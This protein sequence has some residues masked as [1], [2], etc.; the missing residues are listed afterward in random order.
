MDNIKNTTYEQTKQMTFNL[1]SVSSYFLNANIPKLTEYKFLNVTKNKNITIVSFNNKKHFNS[2]NLDLSI[3]LTD[4]NSDIRKGQFYIFKGDETNTFFCTGGDLKTMYMNKDNEEYKELSHLFQYYNFYIS[5]TFYKQNTMFIWNGYTMGSG[6]STGILAKYRVA[7]EST[8]ISMPEALFDYIPNVLYCYWISNFLTLKEALYF[9]IFGYRIKGYDAFV[10]Q[11]ANFYILNEDINNL[12]NDID[13][14]DLLS[15]EYI[16]NALNKY[17]C[18]AIKNVIPDNRMK[19][20]DKVVSI[21]FNFVI[22]SNDFEGFYDKLEM[23]LKAFNKDLYKAFRGREKKIIY[24]SFHLTCLS[25][26]KR[27][28]YE[29]LYDYDLAL[30]LKFI[31]EGLMIDGIKKYFLKEMNSKF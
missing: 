17:H 29:Y 10:K 24:Y 12:L 13:N 20:F 5:H 2:I 30:S 18:K 3:E 26:D 8:V 9:S 27:F 19:S 6:L 16:V 23:R 28:S 21:L 11:F 1:K 25:F 7:T 15:D 4:L 22:D 31:R 14:L